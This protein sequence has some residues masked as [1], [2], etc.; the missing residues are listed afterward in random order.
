MKP[1]Q[2][3][4]F[5][6]EEL[7]GQ[8]Q[9]K[10]FATKE[11][12][13]LVDKLAGDASTR[14][15]YRLFTEKTS[16][17]VCLD[18]PQTDMSVPHAF[19]SKQE[20]LKKAGVRVPDVLDAQLSRG[21]ILEEDL[22]DVTF[23]THLAR[24]SDPKEEMRLYQKVVEQLLT[25]HRLPRASIESSGLFTLA[26]DHE[27]Y[28]QEMDFT[29]KFF[30]G[31]FLKYT[32]EEGIALVRGEFDTIC[33]RLA[34]QPMVLTHRD[35]HSRNIMVKGDE[36]IFIDFQDARW[37]IP[38]YDLV[39]LLEDC[40][41][42]ISPENHERLKRLYFEQL[43][44][45]SHGQGNWET[46]CEFYDDMLLQRVFK[47]VGSF[48]YIYATRQDA[49]YLKYIGYAMEKI[50]CTLMSRPRYQKLR[51]QLFGIYYAS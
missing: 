4:R 45:S 21:Y 6:I 36:L 13:D 19:V 43:P 5:F 46:F 40:Y 14:R 15:Y 29:F 12:L 51:Q 10:G 7:F 35:F 28:M 41:Y 9:D 39:S 32:D 42:Q 48:S 11:K 1:E 34:K 20:F 24:I 37:G 3:E 44:A 23:L 17:V 30:F 18:N 47:A 25:L 22:G 16:Y 50:R 33:Q 49:R 8:S 2:A 31:H 26:F 27:K 38:Q